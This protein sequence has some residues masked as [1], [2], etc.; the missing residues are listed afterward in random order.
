MNGRELDRKKVRIVVHYYDTPS[1]P[2]IRTKNRLGHRTYE[3]R[4]ILP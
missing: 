1:Q 3:E 4:K 2:F